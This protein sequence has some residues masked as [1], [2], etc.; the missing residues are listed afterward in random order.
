MIPAGGPRIGIEI[1]KE[2][3]D[4]CVVVIRVVIAVHT[5]VNCQG[6]KEKE[7]TNTTTTTECHDDSCCTRKGSKR[8]RID[9]PPDTR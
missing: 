7:R 8:T 1:E 4:E 3:N 9:R 6:S 5:I 2:M